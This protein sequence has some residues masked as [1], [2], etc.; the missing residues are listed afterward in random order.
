MSQ[1]MTQLFTTRF[2]T[3]EDAMKISRNSPS[4]TSDRS[5][6]L[7][8]FEKTL[9]SYFRSES[10]LGALSL[11]SYSV[12]LPPALAPGYAAFLSYAEHQGSYYPRG[13]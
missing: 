13:G 7:Q 10:I 9:R 6:M 2:Q 11:G 1:A 12:G 4:M 5:S 8:S 3:F